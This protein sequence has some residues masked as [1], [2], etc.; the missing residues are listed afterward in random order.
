MQE[1]PGPPK[2]TTKP[3]FIPLSSYCPY[4]EDFIDIKQGLFECC[5]KPYIDLPADYETNGLKNLE[6]AIYEYWNK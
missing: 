4:C 3:K 5:F 1:T 6:P 2:N